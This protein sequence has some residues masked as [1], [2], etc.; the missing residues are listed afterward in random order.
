MRGLSKMAVLSIAV[1][2]IG[3]QLFAPPPSGGTPIE[4]RERAAFISSSKAVIGRDWTEAEVS[5]FQTS[6]IAPTAI[7]AQ[8]S[9]EQIVEFLGISAGAGKDWLTALLRL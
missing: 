8:L 6:H 9:P 1:I 7:R 3:G 2:S 5:E 4:E